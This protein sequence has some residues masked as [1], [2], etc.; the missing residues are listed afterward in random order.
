M[1]GALVLVALL[2][3]L[4][5]TGCRHTDDPR[6]IQVVA[7]GVSQALPGLSV[8]REFFS[9][10]DAK[11]YLGRFFA[12]EEFQVDRSAVAVIS[13]TIWRDRFHSRPGVVG[14]KILLD[15]RATTIVGVAGPGFTPNGAGDIWIPKR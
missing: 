5:F 13:Y 1:K 14:S 8:D 2:P 6:Q 12:P 11:A 10:S 3:G 7:D 15:G 9:N 4:D